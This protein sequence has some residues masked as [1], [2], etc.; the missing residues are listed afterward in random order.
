MAIAAEHR[1]TEL[2]EPP[3]GPTGTLAAA[4]IQAASL[5]AINDLFGIVVPDH[6]AIPD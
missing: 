3:P 2:A 1:H 4:T 5:A 6:S